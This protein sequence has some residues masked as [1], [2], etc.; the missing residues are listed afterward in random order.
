MRSGRRRGVLYEPRPL[1]RPR[2]V[3]RAAPIWVRDNPRK[4]SDDEILSIRST[5]HLTDLPELDEQA[6]R[7]LIRAGHRYIG[8]M[9]H[10]P[11]DE[12]RAL[13]GARPYVDLRAAA[14]E[15]GIE[16]GIRAR[17]RVYVP[18]P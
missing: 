15:Q 8:E 9:A 6:Y 7:R 12:L 11:P 16:I 2:K 1:G 14:A 10:V 3:I 18:G 4:L 13:V 17:E 5:R